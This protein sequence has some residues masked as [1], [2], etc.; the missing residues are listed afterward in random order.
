MVAQRA[1]LE[2]AIAELQVQLD[3]GRA[4]LAEIEAARNAAQ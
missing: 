2:E 3:T 1:A 4:Q